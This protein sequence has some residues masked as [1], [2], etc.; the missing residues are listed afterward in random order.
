M[1]SVNPLLLNPLESVKYLPEHEI[2]LDMSI[3]YCFNVHALTTNELKSV[4]S[5]NQGVSAAKSVF[6]LQLE[7]RD[8]FPNMTGSNTQETSSIFN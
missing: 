5:I 8:P 6:D 2:Y 4:F 1:N 7:T 3:S